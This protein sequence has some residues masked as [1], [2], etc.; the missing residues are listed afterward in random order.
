LIRIVD[1][2]EDLTEEFLS[3]AYENKFKYI[4]WQKEKSKFLV[5]NFKNLLI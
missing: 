2:W 4:D 3:E 1:N 5:Q